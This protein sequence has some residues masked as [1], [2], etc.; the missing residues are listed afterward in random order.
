M[1]K[2]SRA[3]PFSI[4]Q[5]ELGKRLEGIFGTKPKREQYVPPPLPTEMKEEP[6][7]NQEPSKEEIK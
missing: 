6:K 2:G 3:R 5:E 4:S 1:S 7:I